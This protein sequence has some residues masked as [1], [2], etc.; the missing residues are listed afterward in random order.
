MSRYG[1]AHRSIDWITL[2]L[3]TMAAPC[4]MYQS[5][6][7]PAGIRNVYYGRSIPYL[8][9]TWLEANRESCAQEVAMAP[10][11]LTGPEALV[12]LLEATMSEGGELALPGEHEE[13]AAYCRARSLRGTDEIHLPNLDTPVA[14]DGVNGRDVEIEV[15]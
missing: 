11:H 7:E 15:R 13:H 6:V 8:R 9:A 3:Y 12:S 5:T 10:L 4:A 2:D 14:Q 1:A